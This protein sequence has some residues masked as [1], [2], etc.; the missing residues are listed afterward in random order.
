MHIN[1]HKAHNSLWP[2]WKYSFGF[3]NDEMI[4]SHLPPPSPDTVILMCGPPP[5]IN[6]AC[7]PN[8]DKLGYKPDA[9]F[10]Y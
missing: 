4:K 10:S 2:G 8:L 3:I 7:I 1:I 5:M 6:F 9:R